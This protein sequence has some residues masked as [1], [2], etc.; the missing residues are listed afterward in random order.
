MA[1]DSA[2]KTVKLVDER[3]VTVTVGEGDAA[4]DSEALLASGRYAK[5][6]SA[7]AKALASAAEARTAPAGTPAK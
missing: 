5:V 7:E 1:R 4:G 6:G 2:V 3:G